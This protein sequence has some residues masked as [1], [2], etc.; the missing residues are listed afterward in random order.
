M[1]N[2]STE[3]FPLPDLTRRHPIAPWVFWPAAVLI[4][5]FSVVAIAFPDAAEAVFGTIQNSIVTTFNWYY[6]AIAA[7]FVGFAIFIGFSRFGDIKLGSDNDEPEFSTGSWFA[8]LF[9]AGMGIGLVFYGVSEPLDHF[10]DPRPGVTGSPAQLAQQ[11]LTQ[12]YLHWG[13]Q[14]WAI[15]VVVGVAIAYAIHR[16]HRSISIRWT[17]EPLLGSRVNGALGNVIDV[18]A[19]VGTLFGVATS[20]GLGILQIGSGLEA[21]GL[22]EFNDLARI[23]L[24]ALISVFVLFSV[25][26]GSAAA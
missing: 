25:L 20:L 18:V 5:G 24:I 14:A 13:L 12:T 6:V 23:G 26:S 10:V 2:P 4:T 9:A 17:L 15:Y 7:F 21:I 11:A 19:L 1:G 22:P 16:R 3:P 8:L